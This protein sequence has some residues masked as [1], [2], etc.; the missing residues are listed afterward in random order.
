MEALALAEKGGKGEGGGCQLTA[1][2]AP[3]NSGTQRIH[4][5]PPLRLF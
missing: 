2:T 4:F 5:P 3:G 1:Q